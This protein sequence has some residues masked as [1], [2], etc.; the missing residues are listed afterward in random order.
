MQLRLYFHR[1]TTCDAIGPIHMMD[2]IGALEKALG[3]HQAGDY[4]AAET[5][6]RDLLK[7]SPENNDGM[8]LLGLCCHALSRN[9]E[10]LSW[11]E[12]A[13][14]QAP[15]EAIF[16]G[17]AGIVALALGKTEIAEGHL[18]LAISINPLQSEPY[19]NLALV[20]QRQGRLQEAEFI[21]DKAIALDPG[22]EKAYSNRG[23]IRR[24]AGDV[25]GAV[26]DYHTAIKIAPEL[27]A[28][29]NGL[30]NALR[31]REQ[32]DDAIA[33]FDKALALDPS[34]AEAYFNRGLTRAVQGEILGAD[35]DLCTALGLRDDPRF[36]I[37]RAGLLP[38][39]PASIEQIEDW[40]R[41]FAERFAAL[42]DIGIFVDGDPSQVSP[43]SFYLAYHGKNDRKLMESVAEFFR[44]R[45]PNLDYVADYCGSPEGSK[46]RPIR[47]GV[48]SR[49]LGEHA[50]ALMIHGLLSELPRD[51]F[52]VTAVTFGG[53][54]SETSFRI[55]EAV[56]AIIV[57]PADIRQAREII[58]AQKFD[59]LLYSDIG[60][61]PLSYFLAFS[62]LAPVQCAT[63]GHPDTTG[64]QTIDYYISNDLAEPENGQESY[65]EKL[66][67]L[68]GVQSRYLR[69]TKPDPLP[70]RHSLGLPKEGTI[71]LCPQ[72]IIKIHPEMDASLAE[73]LR[74][75][76]S[77]QLIVFDGVDQNWTRLLIDRW[78]SILDEDAMSRVTVLSRGTLEVFLG[79]I[80]SADVVLDTWP[81]G[82]GNTNYQTFSMG[83][84]VV[85]FPGS[86]I[87]GRGTLAHYRHM[88]IEGC[89]ATTPDEYVEIAVRLGND[90]AFRSRIADL[91]EARSGAVLEDD[92]CVK[93]LTEF[94]ER[95][96]P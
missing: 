30:G 35:E 2:D 7:V 47:L 55:R 96:A 73:I 10:A 60:M 43:M 85:T 82:A 28:A 74:R 72:N 63:W 42:D 14:A 95:V 29:Y 15:S 57:S 31:D 4:A 37:A 22:S 75:D 92:I 25:D 13:I 27:A 87:R 49:Y 51:R 93:S 81:F 90:T 32:R 56:D 59:I 38:V 78:Q 6:L 11:I 91:I 34:Y 8:H 94:L 19:N 52:H 68:D 50:V 16:L 24:A 40:R 20:R 69:M 89:I 66:V 67:R 46:G 62:R 21:L 23:N 88:D 65:T 83:V 80:A 70:S 17:N 41:R 1:L 48:A 64:L 12:K 54:V 76:P 5:L 33:A 71:Y 58:G 61:E 79:V 53:S 9:E 84:P 86:W 3:L 36:R 44:S 39:I 45:F 26:A 18:E 77:G